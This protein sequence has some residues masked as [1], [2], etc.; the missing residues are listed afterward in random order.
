MRERESEPTVQALFLSPPCGRGGFFFRYFWKYRTKAPRGLR[1]PWNPGTFIRGDKPP[2]MSV[3]SKGGTTVIRCSIIAAPLRRRGLL[4]YSALVAVRESPGG[5]FQNGGTAVPH[6]LVVLSRWGLGRE[7]IETLP[8]PAPFAPLG[9]QRGKIRSLRKYFFKGPRI[10]IRGPCLPNVYQK[11]PAN[12]WGARGSEMG[13]SPSLPRVY[14]SDIF[15][16]LR[17]DF[18]RNR[19]FFATFLRVLELLHSSNWQCFTNFVKKWSK[20]LQKI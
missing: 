11:I 2:V 10:E 19:A 3:P 14:P 6:T 8:P 13:F 15:A 17:P 9:G 16:A 4:F 12:R 7:R 5:C 1:T 18:E 20:M